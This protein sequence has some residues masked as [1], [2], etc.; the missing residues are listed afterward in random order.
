MLF[1][2]NRARANPPAEAQRL[3]GLLQSDPDLQGAATETNVNGFLSQMDSLPSLPPLALNVRLI[4][5]A[6]D[7]D[8]NMLA[9]NAQ[10]HSPSGFLTNPSVATAADGQAFFSTG[11]AAWAIGENI[12]A[13]SQNVTRP[14]AASYVDYFEGGLL[15]DWG[16]PD[17]G[18]LRNLMAPGVGEAIT[19]SHVPF[20]QVGIGLIMGAQPATPSALNVGPAILAQEFAWSAGTQF[21]TGVIYQDSDH[22]G[23]FS[24]G[25]GLGG[26]SITAVGQSGQGTY[27][28]ATWDSGGYSLELP[29][30]PYQVSAT[31]SA[32]GT[33][34]TAVVIGVD[35]FEW[36]IA[37]A[38][39]VASTTPVASA[40]VA[41]P[42]S[43]APQAAILAAT[44]PGS[45]RPRVATR[46]A[47]AAH[48]PAIAPVIR[49]RQPKVSVSTVG[50][51]RPKPAFKHAATHT[52][53][54]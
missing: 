18:H 12:F 52:I 46:S 11:N 2:I 53:R 42:L 54:P 20:N 13:Y 43:S 1:E 8:Q 51:P 15:L 50:H 7:E 39:P 22:N 26:V 5:A 48:P 37:L 23:A 45:Q 30:G 6:L 49:A 36:D 24:I 3:L 32:F 47:S 17:F 27:Q 25:E 33:R 16:N 28:T 44:Q 40:P 35:N 4:E 38:G 34:T 21:L 10:M 29:P 19:V 9:A 14:S 31:S 41:P